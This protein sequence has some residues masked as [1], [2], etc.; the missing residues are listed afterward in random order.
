LSLVTVGTQFPKRFI[1]DDSVRKRAKRAGT[2]E[3]ASRVIYNEA[4][5][6]LLD[7]VS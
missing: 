5:R 2:G 4:R 1:P 7:V 6:G 3:N